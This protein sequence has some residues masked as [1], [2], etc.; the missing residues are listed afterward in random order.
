[1]KY[2][3][4]C[5][6]TLLGSA[7]SFCAVCG[8]KIPNAP[9]IEPEDSGTQVESPTIAK[10]TD[11]SRPRKPLKQREFAPKKQLRT[12]PEQ[13]DDGYDGYYDDVPPLDNGRERERLDP[14]MIKKICLIIV[15]ALAIIGLSV[16]LMFVL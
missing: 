11:K 2:C 7:A 14:E 10:P 15:G 16:A 12:Q 13:H 5:G 3:P 8:K 4:Y 1:M 6:A 9:Q